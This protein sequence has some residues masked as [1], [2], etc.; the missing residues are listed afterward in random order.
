VRDRAAQAGVPND[1][2]SDPYPIPD[3]L[4][5]A[6]SAVRRLWGGQQQV[7]DFV[8]DSPFM[9]FASGRGLVTRLIVRS[10]LLCMIAFLLVVFAA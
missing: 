8:D 1:A 6:G 5:R 4:L 10:F 2:G 9:G 3:P 7:Q